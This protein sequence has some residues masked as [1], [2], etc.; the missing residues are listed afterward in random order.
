MSCP[1]HSPANVKG[2]LGHTLGVPDAVKDIEARRAPF[3]G[4]YSRKAF[5]M[6]NEVTEAAL[7]EI[8]SARLPQFA[9]QGAQDA[10]RN[11]RGP[12]R[13]YIREVFRRVGKR[14][15]RMGLE[16][17]QEKSGGIS[18]KQDVEDSW[19]REVEKFLRTGG[20]GREIRNISQTIRQDIVNIL[21]ETREDGAGAE[22]MAQILEEEIEEVNRRRGRVI[23]RTEVISA[24]NFGSQHGAKQTGLTLEKVWV[25][26]DDPRVRR[27]HRVVDGQQIPIDDPYIWESPESG[28]VQADFPGDPSLPAAERIQCRCVEIHEPV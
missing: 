22:E 26:S 27:S 9:I 19:F 17:V 10:V 16:D 4:P 24:S 3:F 2:L 1:V 7:E 21:A 13:S 18:T 15:A 8:R 14:F 25:D 6:R 28:R 12:I 11:T 23:A 20:G 5:E